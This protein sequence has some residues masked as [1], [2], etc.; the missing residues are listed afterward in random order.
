[1]I[2]LCDAPFV[3]SKLTRENGPAA[4]TVTKTPSLDYHDQKADQRVATGYSRWGETRA[5]YN[6]MEATTLH[7]VSIPSGQYYDSP[8]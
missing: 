2:D 7:S 3:V 1:M 4:D 6:V 5:E 8:T